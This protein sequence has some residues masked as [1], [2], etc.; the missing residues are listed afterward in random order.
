MGVV[1]LVCADGC[2]SWC[3]LVLGVLCSR[4]ILCP[5]GVF[6]HIFGALQ[7]AVVAR[8]FRVF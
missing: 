8:F 6:F 4:Y 1:C 7:V 5:L 3:G 2:V